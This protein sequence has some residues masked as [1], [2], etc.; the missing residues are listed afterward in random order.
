[1][2]HIREVGEAGGGGGGGLNVFVCLCVRRRLGECS[3]LEVT[4][5]D[6]ECSKISVSN[7]DVHDRTLPTVT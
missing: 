1:M 6:G 7:H 5:L 4:R 2:N 3:S